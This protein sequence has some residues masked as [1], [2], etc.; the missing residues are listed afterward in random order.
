MSTSNNN[1]Q[2]PTNLDVKNEIVLYFTSNYS[3]ACSQVKHMIDFIAPHFNTK[4]INIDN[5]KMR[6]V[7][8]NATINKIDVVPAAMLIYPQTNEI[9]IKLVMN[10]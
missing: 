1:S 9:K 10:Y 3:T 5:P 8:L 7:L 4:V 6:S 2:L